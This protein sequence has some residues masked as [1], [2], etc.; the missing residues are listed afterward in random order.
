MTLTLEFIFTRIFFVFSF[1]NKDNKNN[2]HIQIPAQTP[3]LT[4][5]VKQTK[6]P[7]HPIGAESVI[8]IKIKHTVSV[9]IH[10]ITYTLPYIRP[11]P[12]LI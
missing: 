12:N 4:H 11:Y 5:E 6:L 9:K 3:A 2:A 1:C 10:P 7:N 8:V